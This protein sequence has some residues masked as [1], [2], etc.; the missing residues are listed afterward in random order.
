ME[1]PKEFE[2]VFRGVDL[3]EDE[4]RVPV[5]GAEEFQHGDVPVFSPE[6][7]DRRRQVSVH[8]R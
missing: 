2:D 1:M 3:T 7:S 8:E 4:I 5:S 6:G